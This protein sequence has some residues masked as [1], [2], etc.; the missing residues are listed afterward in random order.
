[1]LSAHGSTERLTPFPFSS[2]TIAYTGSEPF[3]PDGPHK[4]VGEAY[5]AIMESC[6]RLN[7][8][9]VTIISDEA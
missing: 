5:N 2:L 4:T 1:M 3:G 7:V 6:D 8:E 9:K